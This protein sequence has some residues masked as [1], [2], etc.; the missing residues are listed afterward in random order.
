MNEQSW[1]AKAVRL[2]AEAF[3]E[4][5]GVTARLREESLASPEITY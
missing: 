3:G 2:T 5:S 4:D 1:G